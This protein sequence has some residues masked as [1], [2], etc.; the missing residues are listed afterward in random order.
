[1]L[2]AD[3]GQGIDELL[4][5]IEIA[6]G[7]RDLPAAERALA[8]ART[9]VGAED[10]VLLYYEASIRWE[11]DGP[12]AAIGRLVRVVEAAPD[13]ADA[14]HAL[15]IA[16]E[17]I[18]DAPGMV[19]HFLETLR[20]DTHDDAQAG[21]G[22]AA[23]LDFIERTAQRCIE[24]I[25]ARFSHHLENVPVVIEARPHQDLVKEGFDPRSLGLFEGDEH[26]AEDHVVT[27]PTRIVLYAN[28]L[29]ASFED[30]DELAEEIEITILH[31]VGHFFGL[32]EDEVAE[33]GLE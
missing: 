17:Q 15:G 1:M 26:G 33:L 27:A 24:N 14:H 11:S 5:L 13:F 18:G 30:N 23:Q 19:R 4:D 6:L 2:D 12:T 22:T 31:E 25:P 7:E 32:D 16:Y 10:P 9:R 21:L 8:E 28:N 29:L 20:L 3:Q